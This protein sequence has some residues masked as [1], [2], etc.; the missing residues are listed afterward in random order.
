[1][2][3]NEVNMSKKPEV[4]SYAQKELDKAEKKFDEFNDSI[5]EMTLDRMNTA[6]KEE[7]EPQAKISTREAQKSDIYL[8]P[9]RSVSSKEKFNENYRNEYNFQKEYVQFIAE[10]K[11][12]GE[13]IETWTKPF[14][15]MPAEFWKVPVNKSVWGPRYLAEQIKR[16]FYHRLMMQNNATSQETGMT[17]YGS[18]SI[19]TTVQRLDARPVSQR[20]SVFMGANNF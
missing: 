13:T 19:D 16:K 14:A 12:L 9:D 8:K 17:Y 7:T 18:L 20:K 3:A 6:P 15:G 2:S 4:S 11:E 1:M 5:K 10:H